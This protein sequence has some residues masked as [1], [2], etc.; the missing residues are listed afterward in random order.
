[1]REEREK[2]GAGVA[3]AE[4][5]EYLIVL[6][7]NIALASGLDGILPWPYVAIRFHKI[8]TRR[9]SNGDSR[10]RVRVQTNLEPPLNCQHRE[11]T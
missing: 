8:G 10:F 2:D 4:E 11:P 7:L 6:I 1:M 3:G 9:R 5:R